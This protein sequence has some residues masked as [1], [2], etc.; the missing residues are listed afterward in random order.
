[1]TLIKDFEGVIEYY[2]GKTNAVT[3]AHR[4]GLMVSLS[5]LGTVGFHP[6]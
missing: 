4:R 1:M 5:Y 2:T 6:C 3:H